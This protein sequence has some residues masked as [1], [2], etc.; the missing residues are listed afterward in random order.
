MLVL[1]EKFFGEM[2]L[3]SSSVLINANINN[4]QLITNI[5]QEQLIFNH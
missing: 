1:L 5:N 2:R 3:L 4:Q